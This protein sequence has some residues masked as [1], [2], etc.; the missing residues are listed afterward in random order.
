[1]PQALGYADHLGALPFVIKCLITDSIQC[2][3]AMRI[4]MCRCSL[5]TML[6]RLLDHRAPRHPLHLRLHC[7]VPR[8]SCLLVPNHP[9]QSRVSMRSTQLCSGSLPLR[10]AALSQLQH[11]LRRD[12]RRLT[13]VLSTTSTFSAT[14]TECERSFSAPEIIVRPHSC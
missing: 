9:R 11:R 2:W 10:S 13:L 4:R 7:Q 5:T 8:P 6:C 12:A 3:V 1:M 14:G